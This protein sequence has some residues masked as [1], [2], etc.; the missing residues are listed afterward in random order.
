MQ[1]N[2]SRTQK[3]QQL[4]NMMFASNRHDMTV[5]TSDSNSDDNSNGK[6]MTISW[7]QDQQW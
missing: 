6:N 3:L 2:P 1:M 5:M 4:A 7:H